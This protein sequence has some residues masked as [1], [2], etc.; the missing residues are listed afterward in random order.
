M[1]RVLILSLLLLTPVV[2]A[3]GVQ[4]AGDPTVVYP[5]GVEVV[6]IDS[7]SSEF[8]IEAETA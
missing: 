5:P 7:G 2:V 4:R 3:I 1:R 8:V 6:V